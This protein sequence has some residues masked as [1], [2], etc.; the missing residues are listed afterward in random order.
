[1]DREG[2]IVM[3]NRAEIDTRAPFRSVKEAV[4]L[5]GHKVLSGQLYPTKL[6]EE[7]VTSFS[8]AHASVHYFD[9]LMVPKSLNTI[10]L[11][12]SSC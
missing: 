7:E 10:V 6:K 2:G 1:M 12:P 5:F 3:M 9:L 11:C 4:A 8:F